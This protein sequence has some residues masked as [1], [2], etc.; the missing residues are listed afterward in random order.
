M[1]TAAL[2]AQ[3]MMKV[4]KHSHGGGLWCLICMLLVRLYLSGGSDVFEL[5]EF[6]QYSIFVCLWMS[7]LA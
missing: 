3:L 4:H 1:L 6:E 5:A 2:I 7:G